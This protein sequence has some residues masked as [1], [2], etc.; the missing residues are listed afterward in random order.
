MRAYLC[1]TG[2]LF[3]LLAIAHLLRTFA[4]WRRLTTDGWFYLEGPGIGLLGAALSFWAWRLL[5]SKGAKQTT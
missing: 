1:I 5:R 3:G 2:S 4:E